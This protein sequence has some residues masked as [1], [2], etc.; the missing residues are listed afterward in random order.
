MFPH[1][2]SSKGSKQ[3]VVAK[4][5]RLFFFQASNPNADDVWLQLFDAA[6]AG[7]ITLGSTAPKLSLCIP[8][9]DGTKNSGQSEHFEGGL[10]FS[11]GLFYA[12]TT[13]E[14][15]A[16]VPTSNIRMNVGYG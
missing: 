13:T 3:T 11:L 8:A 4:P 12:F 14:T 9:G 2:T 1:T 16:G 10:N 15:G 6:S 7:D 5:C